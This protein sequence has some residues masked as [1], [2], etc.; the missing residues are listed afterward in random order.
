MSIDSLKRRYI[1]KLSTNFIGF[2][3]SLVTAGIVP[4]AL[5]VNNYG[6]FNFAT[7]I[8]NQIL[9]FL[10]FKTSTCFY[11]KLSQRQRESNL[12]LFYAYYTI[13]ILILL[14]IIISVIS[15]TSLKIFIFSELSIS[16]IYYA[17]IYVILF[18]I[19][20]LLI[21]V[22]D[23]NGATVP[24]EQMRI[25][26]KIIS[27]VIILSLYF[28]TK[29]TLTMYFYYMFGVS[30]ALIIP[31]F[32]YIKRRI[33]YSIKLFPLLEK[34][35]V[36]SYIKEFS[37][38]SSPLALY[39]ILSFISLSF[40]RWILQ[41]SG[42]SFQQ[43][44]YSFSF[45]LTNY[46]FMFISAMFPLFTRELSIFAR[47]NDILGMAR[48]FRR[49]V[50]LLYSL[51]A[52]FA[53]FI[54]VNAESIIRIFGGVNYLSATT[55]LK[56][57]A[58]LPLISTYSMLNGAVVYANGNTKIFLKIAL[59][60]TPI[61]MITTFILISGKFGGLNLGANGLAIKNVI[62]EFISVIIILYINSRYLKIK[63]LRYLLHMIISIIPVTIIAYLSR[64]FIAY[65]FQTFTNSTNEILIVFFAGLLYSTVT[66]LIVIVFPR[67]FGLYKHDIAYMTKKI[68]VLM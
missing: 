68:R 26:N 51:S 29:L 60:F 12:L 33:G 14:V 36:V 59:I 48:L 27:T 56:I 52:Y 53:C 6:N 42:G 38:Y 30:L 55:S 11:T 28:Y 41:I 13:A 49:Y 58:I 15:M 25:I 32:I 1:Y 7:T 50:P 8:V 67:L 37:I 54:F 63:Y 16:I 44:L 2:L 46:T 62:F 45:T 23:A 47:D 61:G 17:V 20:G 40:D 65:I 5:G 18:W 64:Y 10:D 24:L 43:G 31:I 22:M 34:E 9:T 21:K 39:V 4:R 66:M 3:I 57:L 19:L 35:I